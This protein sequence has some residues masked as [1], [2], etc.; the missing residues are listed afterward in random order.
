MRINQHSDAILR[1]LRS[2][3][4]SYQIPRGG[5]FEFVSAPHYLGEIMEWIG[6]A[7][8]NRFSLASV[9]FVIYTASNL[10]PRAVAHHHWYRRNFV[11]DY[12]PERRAIVPF[13]L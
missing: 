9:A 3:S 12:P 1:R 10:I 5:M 8:A 6:F 2:Q 13:V 7:I 11:D 4:V